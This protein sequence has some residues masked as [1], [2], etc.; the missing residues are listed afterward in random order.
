MSRIDHVFQSYTRTH[1]TRIAL[2]DDHDRVTYGELDA[3]VDAVARQL[4]QAG[5][6]PGD[7][8]LLVA[9]NS[10][11]LALT[12]LA[13]SRL[14]AWSA[15]V[16]A[17]LSAREI[18]NFLLH[19]GA[20]R[21]VYFS[22]G[23]DEAARHGE[24]QGAQLLHW[25]GIGALMLGPLQS[26]VIAEPA[27]PDVAALVYTSGTTGAPKA[28][29]LTHANLLFIGA[30]SCKIR[31]LTPDDVIYGVL[32]LSHV[33]GL[34]ALLVAAL[35][36]G[37][38]LR[39][40]PR[41]DALAMAQALAQDGVTVLHGVP[42]MYA[43]LLATGARLAAPTLRVAQSGG[44][45]LS[46]SLKAGFE[47]CFGI[48]LHNGYGMTEAAPS[49]CQTRMEL[50]RTDCS[51]GHAI[52]GIEI[53]LDTLMQDG[54]GI[55][56]LQVRG[57]NVMAGYY[58]A[59][60]ASADALTADG[61]LHTGD[62]ARIDADGAVTIVGRSKELIIRSGFNVYPVEV[63]QVLNAYPG[64]VQSAVIGRSSA[65]NEEVLA[66]IEVL[67]TIVLDREHLHDY[68]CANLSPYKIPA[69]IIALASLPAAASGKILKRELHKLASATDA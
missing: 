35:A 32:P 31:A 56:E 3:R 21:A 50:P 7:R 53:R 60:E 11:A 65:D 67:P 19:S 10:V 62:L 58:R 38:A 15:S 69:E 6:R 22:T 33:Y 55:G 57:P 27:A 42:A 34:S 39:L 16:N 12:I 52:E 5:V 49:I 64:I 51:V 46:A 47:A 43:K 44:A 59:P 40:V 17:R 9:E 61:W 18:D 2:Q 54:D 63:E 48:P 20:R 45:P 1:A 30:N 66:F 36:S 23:S 24:A 25:D 13:T 29:M 4:Q 14:R 41:F 28:V 26:E 8:V 68:L 37:A